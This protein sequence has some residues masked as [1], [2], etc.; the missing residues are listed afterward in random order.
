MTAPP[1]PRPAGRR[2]RTVYTD[3]RFLT[4]AAANTVLLL[5]DSMLFILIPLW[6]VRRCGLPPTVSSILLVLNT[7]ITV[8]IQVHAAKYAKGSRGALRVLRWAVA[9]LAAAS[10]FLGLAGRGPD[11]ELIIMLAVAVILLTVGENL[12]AVAGWELSFVLSPPAQRP[13]YLSLFSLGYT[14]QLIIGPVLMTAVVL[15]WGMPGVALMT[16]LF[17]VA[18]AVTWVAVR[19]AGPEQVAKPRQQVSA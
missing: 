3:G 12:Q 7:V 8:L 5:H 6:V 13:Q 2:P 15:P 1:P 11:W 17:V 9:A 16:G 19:D 10:I 18:A 4:V 14:G